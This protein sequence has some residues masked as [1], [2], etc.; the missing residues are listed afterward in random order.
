MGW[1]YKILCL[2]IPMFGLEWDRDRGNKLLLTKMLFS[3]I[4]YNRSSIQQSF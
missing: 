3:A 1:G 4:I 2:Y